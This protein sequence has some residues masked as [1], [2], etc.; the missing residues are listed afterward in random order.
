M[1]LKK[2]AVVVVVTLALALVFGLTASQAVAGVGNQAPSGAH[3]N[4]NIIGVAKEKTA[5][6]TGSNGHVI[7]VPLTEKKRQLAGSDPAIYVS[8]VIQLVENT[9][10]DTF[11]VLDANGTDGDASFTL[12]NP[13]GGAKYQ[14]YARALGK[15]S[16][17]ATMTAG[18]VDEYGNEW[19]SVSGQVLNLEVMKAKDFRNVSD[20]LFTVTVLVYDATTG[21]Y[22]TQVLPIFDPMFQGYFWAYDNNG[23]KLLQLRFYEVQ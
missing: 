17:W 10:D 5:D 6:M 20:Y 16:G 7:F 4:L 23:L 22:V 15:P 14:V 13:Q 2:L 19:L 12:P 21:T 3:Y 9:V 8:C 11:Q 1:T 18:Y